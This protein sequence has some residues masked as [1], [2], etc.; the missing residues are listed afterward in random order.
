MSQQMNFAEFTRRVG[1]LGDKLKGDVSALIGL[2]A[3][4]IV[5]EAVRNAPGPG[6][7]IATERGS[8]TQQDIARDRAW[9]PIS[10]AIAFELESDGMAALVYVE[11][12]AGELAVY[13]EVGTG[14]SAR[15]YLA[16]LS[17]EWQAAARKFYI[18]GK[19]T[20]VNRPYMYPAIQKYEVIFI[21]ELR[22]LLKDLRI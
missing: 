13:V 7:P 2:T 15:S 11:K 8:E 20:I 10:Q 14:Q 6:D 12:A 16:T 4:D 3:S 19:G 1:Q 5:L 17:P 21:K 22:E 18:N 9:V